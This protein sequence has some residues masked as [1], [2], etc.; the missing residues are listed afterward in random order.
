MTKLLNL[1]IYFFDFIDM[2]Y[3]VLSRVLNLYNRC[4]DTDTWDD[5]SV[6]KV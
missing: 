4:R 5:F 1:G 3:V 2:M 6:G